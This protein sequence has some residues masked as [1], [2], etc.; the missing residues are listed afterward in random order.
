MKKIYLSVL[1][2]LAFMLAVAS[3]DIY[4]PELA[5]PT[6]NQAGVAPNVELDWNAVAGQ[7]GVHYE[8]QLSMDEAFTNPAVFTTELTAFRMSNLLFGT[9]YFWRVR[10]IDNQGTSDWSF[11]WSFTVLD[12]TSLSSPSNDA[13]KQAP[14]AK[15]RWS[16]V[17][18]AT[19]Y[20]Y[21][22]DVVSTFDSPY[23]YTVS[24]N[25]ET[26]NGLSTTAEVNTANLLFGEKH[27]WRV[28]ARHTL[29]TSEWS[30]SR[31]FTVI[32][33]FE[34]LEPENNANA[35][36]P[37]VLFEWKQI[38]GLQKYSISLATDEQFVNVTKYDVASNSTSY[39]PDTLE[40]GTQYF[41]QIS[42][43]H[44]KD[45]LNAG[46][47]SLNIVDKVSL[48]SPANNAT[49][50]ELTPFLKWEKISGTMLYKLELA[51]NQAMTGAFKYN[52]TATT[53]AGQEQFKVP[54]NI[55]DSTKTYYWRVLAISS[56]DTSNW[57][58]TWNFRCVSLGVEEPAFRN[59][60]KIYPSPATE[61]VNIQLKS[62]LNGKATI[63]L[64][65]LLGKARIEREVQIVNGM[66]KDFQLGTLSNGIYMLRIDSSG[67]I[68]TSKVILKR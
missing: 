36:G 26:V 43:I 53:T 41:W 18:G 54:G 7:L 8:A 11:S 4:A 47:F 52:V 37:D 68:A 29:D 67:V 66:I 61:T 9:Q 64:F 19:H 44:A 16:I 42:A 27:Y 5:A 2:S 63:T 50:T 30:A 1:A 13:K 35:L 39:I 49:N 33:E 31:F 55:L 60:M 48:N 32:G 57:S 59:G 15:I 25:A 12:Q 51:S 40:F 21:Q 34:N 65:D 38:S 24:C 3:P 14:N 22:M 10:A 20:D 46:P 62:G 58:E 6:N 28:R 56:R 17:G 23:A 45:T